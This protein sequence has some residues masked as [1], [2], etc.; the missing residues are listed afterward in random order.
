MTSLKGVTSMNTHSDALRTSS[1]IFFLCFFNC[2]LLIPQVI[3]AQDLFSPSLLQDKVVIV[4]G[5][6][7][8]IGGAI[9]RALAQHGAIVVFVDKDKKQG[10]Q[11]SREL[12]NMSKTHLFVPGDL[13]KEET[14]KQVIEETL[15]YFDRIDILINNAGFNDKIGL[16]ASPSA[17]KKSVETNLMHYFMMLHYALTSLKKSKGT[18][19]NI[20]SK[21]ALTGQGSTSGYAAAKGAIL[22]LTREWAVEL[23]PYDIRVNAVIPAE[24]LTEAYK[25]WI[26]SFSNH[27]QKLQQ[28]KEKIPLGQRMT[29]M[30]EIANTVLFLASPL[31]SHTTG[32]FLSVDGGYVHLDRAF[33]ILNEKND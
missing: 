1:Y 20:A 8:G 30:Q 26:T 11:L 13:S 3:H 29:T 23:A 28:I 12:S 15:K 27:E 25:T 21:V 6:A 10:T 2:L 24:V 7:A 19:I 18:V 22:A 5:G 14:C 16:T 17:F 33:T 32:Q 4:T 9:V 31:A